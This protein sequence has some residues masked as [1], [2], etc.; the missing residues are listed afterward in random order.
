[1]VSSNKIFALL[2]AVVA[3]SVCVD[4]EQEAAQTFGMF[5]GG[6]PGTGGGMGGGLS[7]LTKMIP[8]MGGLPGMGGGGMSG[9]GGGFSGLT[10][11]LPGMGGGG[12][13]SGMSN[14]LSSLTN[15]IPGLGAGGASGMSGGLPGMGGGMSGGSAKTTTGLTGPGSVHAPDLSTGTGIGRCWCWDD[16]RGRND[17]DSRHYW[18]NRDNKNCWSYWRGS[19][20]IP[21]ASLG[22][23]ERT[24]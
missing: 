16:W 9:L 18:H 15:M 13:T 8:S 21:S 1:M 5:G 17:R 19:A 10:K 7:S 20:N 23:N 12:G 6:L 4:A 14:G 3:L 11:M 22:V 24:L 2:V